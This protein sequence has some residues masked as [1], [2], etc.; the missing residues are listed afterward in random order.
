MNGVGVRLNADPGVQQQQLA[1]LKEF[2]RGDDRL[3]EWRR[4]EYP[5]LTA[6]FDALADVP[7]RVWQEAHPPSRDASRDAFARLTGRE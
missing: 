6:S 7:L 4:L 3:R 1:R 2:A 5:R